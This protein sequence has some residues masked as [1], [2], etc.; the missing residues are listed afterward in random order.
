M[1][2]KSISID[3]AKTAF[4]N[5]VC[6]NI[7]KKDYSLARVCI[8]YRRVCHTYQTFCEELKK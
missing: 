4:I 1:S 7:C 3:K 2:K 8:T 6:V 5:T